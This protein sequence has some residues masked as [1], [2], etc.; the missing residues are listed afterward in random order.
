MAVGFHSCAGM[1]K[2]TSAPSGIHAQSVLGPCDCA[3]EEVSDMSKP[4]VSPA[5]NVQVQNSNSQSNSS[6]DFL[7]GYLKLWLLTLRLL[8]A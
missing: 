6:A 3:M 5:L 1:S 2:C 4:F 8:S 7:V